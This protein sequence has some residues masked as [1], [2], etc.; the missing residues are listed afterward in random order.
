MNIEKIAPVIFLL[1]LVAFLLVPDADAAEHRGGIIQREQREVI[2]LDEYEKYFLLIVMHSEAA[3][4]GGKGLSLVGE[5]V[6]NRYAHVR[7]RAYDQGHNM[8]E[9]DLCDVIFAKHQFESMPVSWKKPSQGRKSILRTITRHSRGDSLP[10]EYSL[11]DRT[12]DRY[13]LKV[14]DG[15]L[16]RTAP[17][18]YLFFHTTYIRPYWADYRGYDIKHARHVFYDTDKNGSTQFRWGSRHSCED[19]YRIFLWRVNSNNITRY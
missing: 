2:V 10:R 17:S 14:Y 9:I 18:M 5:V 13:V 7:A 6:M 11:T 1:A 4:E 3:S 16:I 15:K 19:L 12:I 8:D